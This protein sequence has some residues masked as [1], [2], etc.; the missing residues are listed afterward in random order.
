MGNVTLVG[1]GP[2]DP[3][4]VTLKGLQ[5]I[6]KADCII[7]DR[8]VDPVLLSYAKESCERIY[9]GKKASHHTMK[10]EEIN[11][12]LA[13]KAA[14]KKEV[15]RLKGGDPYVFGRGAEEALYLKERGIPFQIVPGI[16]SCIAA[17]TYAGIPITHRDIS[18][19]FYVATAH[20]KEDIM[21]SLDMGLI[22]NDHTIVLLMGLAHVAAIVQ[23]LLA[24][25]KSP[26]TPVAVISHATLPAQDVVV[27]DLLHITEAVGK[28]PLT[29]PA[30]IV[31]GDV[32]KL[33]DELTFFE[34]SLLFRAHILLPKIGNR[35]LSLALQLRELGAEVEEIT[36]GEIVPCADMLQGIALQ[37]YSCILFTSRN[38]VRCFMEDMKR[39]RR[40][41][42]CLAAMKIAAIGRSTAC[43]LEEYGIFADLLP[44][45]FHQDACFDMMKRHMKETDHLLFPHVKGETALAKKLSGICHVTE[46]AAYENRCCEDVHITEA[47]V[48][49]ADFIVFTCSSSVHR[50]MEQVP[51]VKPISAHIVSIGETTSR[52][53]RSYGMDVQQAAYASYEAVKECILELWEDK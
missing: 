36:L 34:D 11:A 24:A 13:E 5:S 10:Q 20:T 21:A 4:L 15:V 44:K 42:R 2:G 17:L 6:Q 32:V 19:S 9:V 40:D 53:L 52:T 49:Q 25:G 46:I 18:G 28:H 27:S 31:I 38:A 23:Q 29:S 22:Q 41:L 7:Y 33:R 3:S 16:S 12:L 43:C 51:L 8:L 1:A 37:D 45:E 50:F 39:N 26:H 47:M 48:Q 35:P 30:V 14:Q